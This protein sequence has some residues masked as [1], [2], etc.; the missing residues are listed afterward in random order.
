M[1]TNDRQTVI[2]N[3]DITF[4]T[5]QQMSYL[6]RGELKKMSITC[7]TVGVRTY[8]AQFLEPGIDL[9]TI[10]AAVI[11]YIKEAV[12][13]PVELV[14]IKAEINQGATKLARR[15]VETG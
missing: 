10:Q 4:R 13:V 14:V 9:V 3:I 7:N 6:S 15:R 11:A 12:D 5:P 2:A 8:L 1:K